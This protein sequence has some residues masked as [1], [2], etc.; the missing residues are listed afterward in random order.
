MKQILPWIGALISGGL[1]ALCY[2]PVNWGGL[3]WIALT[4]LISALWF[5]EP[6]SR[7]ETLRRFL[8]GY[9]TGAA[10]F[11]GCFHW[12]VT[13]TVAG[14]IALC[15]FL[16]IYPALWAVLVAALKP[17]QSPFEAR[18][19]WMKSWNNLLIAAAAAAGWVGLE[20]LREVVFTGFGWNNLGIALHEN[21]ALI[22]ICDLTGVG[23]LSFLIVM[24][25]LI[26]VLTAKRLR[27]EIGHH[28]LRPHYDF[29]LTVALV[30]IVF[31][32]G[33]R[34][35]FK[36]PVPS[37]PISIAAIQGNVPIHEKRDPAQEEEILEEHIRLTEDA[38]AMQP[39]LI[40]WPEAATPQPLF[41]D[42]RS[43]D[44]VRSLAEKHSGDFLLGTVNL[45]TT[46][47]FNSAVLLTENGRTAQT[48]NKIHLVPFGEFLPFRSLV[49]YPAW[50]TSQVPGDFDSG[51][52][53]TLLEMAHRPVK[54]AALIC[55]EDTLGDLARRFVR[56]GAQLFVVLTNDGWFLKSAGARQHVQHSIFRC[57]ETKIPMVRAAN[58]GLTCI[59]D[60]HGRI[61]HSLE[62]AEGGMFF[63]GIL[64]SEVDVPQDPKMTFYTRYG[65]AFSLTCLGAGILTGGFL[66][67]RRREN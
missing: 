2:A 14:W 58:T 60:S 18:P 16:A 20:W 28:K 49:P 3:V 41:S 52:E 59:I 44:V 34:E 37:A 11:I 26:L 10:Y 39:D 62:D 47:D 5:S 56:Q 67:L 38:M 9:V 29:S 22:Q 4:P 19:V 31:G 57:A 55:F 23:G 17:R 13:V 50:V 42:Q 21:I 7:R 48:Y 43:W 8:L 1:L 40:I 25:N 66:I 54:I 33:V 32:Y 45:D 30:A 24:V 53:P 51:R 12:L 65:D 64:F 6:W 61:L 15:L 63:E 27:V 36:K 35:L 46:G